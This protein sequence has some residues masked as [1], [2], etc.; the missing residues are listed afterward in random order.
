MRPKGALPAV[1]A[2]AGFV[3][4]VVGV[5]QDLLHV[6]PGYE[7]TITTGWDGSLSHEELLLARLGLVGVVGAGAAL[8]WRRL[9]V[10]PAATGVV[11]LLY[12]LRAVLQYARDP[13]LYAPVT[14]FGG[15]SV[16]FVLGAEPFLLVAGGA[17]LVAAGAAGWS[18]C[19]GGADDG[20]SAAASPSRR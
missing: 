5:H 12:A 7:G 14:A 6:A 18:A 16:R 9:A 10:V 2:L 4:I 15:E 17:L 3:A 1:L 8:R 19:S 11:V 20:A 13:G